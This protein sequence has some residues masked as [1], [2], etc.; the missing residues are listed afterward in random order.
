MTTHTFKP[1][2]E[3]LLEIMQEA[4]DKEVECIASL[5]FSKA[6]G[7]AQR[8][9][10]LTMFLQDQGI[11]T[12]LANKTAGKLALPIPDNVKVD[13]IDIYHLLKPLA[14]SGHATLKGTPVVPIMQ[15]TLK[16]ICDTLEGAYSGVQA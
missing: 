10:V 7:W 2:R 6:T 14:D 8:A 15:S 11:L 12:L 16:N 4:R 3:A 5:E 9:T 1:I 13:M